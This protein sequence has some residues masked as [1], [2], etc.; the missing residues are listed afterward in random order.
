MGGVFEV[1]M[2]TIVICSITALSIILSGVWNTGGESGAALTTMAFNTSLPVIG[3]YIV[4]IGVLLFAYST[5]L[6]WSYYG[7][8]RCLEFLFGPKL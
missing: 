5:I 4:S 8:E 3:G 1:F 7:G 6:S 2:D